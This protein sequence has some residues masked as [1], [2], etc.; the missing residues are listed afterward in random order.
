[1][2]CLYWVL[3]FLKKIVDYKKIYERIVIIIIIIII[4]TIII[5]IIIIIII[6]HYLTPNY[7]FKI[8]ITHSITR[9]T[10]I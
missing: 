1:M 7:N 10:I 8:S 2:L 3:I 9:I 4:I 5:I 6:F